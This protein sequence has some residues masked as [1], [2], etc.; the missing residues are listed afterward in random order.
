M[1]LKWAKKK[2]WYLS[3]LHTKVMT[4]APYLSSYFELIVG[5]SVVVHNEAAACNHSYGWQSILLEI[6]GPLSGQCA[7]SI[8]L[9]IILLLLGLGIVVYAPI[10]NIACMYPIKIVCFQRVLFRFL[11]F[12]I[13]SFWIFLGQNSLDS[14]LVSSS[15]H[16]LG[17][18]HDFHDYS[19]SFRCIIQLD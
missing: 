18:Y 9:R 2:L 4:L 12:F 10:A 1:A 6:R 7:Y 19:L 14:W 3:V 15:H 8:L 13:F 11:S 17:P 16:I 5:F